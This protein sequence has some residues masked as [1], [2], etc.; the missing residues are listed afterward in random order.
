MENVALISPE[1]YKDDVMSLKA[2]TR[3]LTVFFEFV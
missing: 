3:A 2:P 1:S